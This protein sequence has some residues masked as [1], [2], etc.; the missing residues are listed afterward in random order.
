MISKRAASIGGSV[1]GLRTGD[2]Y[3]LRELLYALLLVS[4]NDAAIAIA[5]HVG[6]SVE[7][8]AAMMN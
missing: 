3:A 1:V 5:E 6:G 8:F 7:G 4:A 2:R